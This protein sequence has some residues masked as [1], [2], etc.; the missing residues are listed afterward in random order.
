[1]NEERL[2]AIRL[3]GN[4]YYEQAL[5]ILRPARQR[6]DAHTDRGRKDEPPQKLHI[7][8]GHAGRNGTAIDGRDSIP[9][10]VASCLHPDDQ[11]AARGI[12]ERSNIRGEVELITNI[13]P[14][15]LALRL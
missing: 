9:I 12:A 2:Q 1:M 7:P 11:H 13:A 4:V 15:V 10:G 14:V 8:A 6:V 5:T 3:L